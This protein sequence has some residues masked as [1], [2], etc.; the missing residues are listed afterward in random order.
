VRARSGQVVVLG[1]LMKEILNDVVKK[2][3]ILG[4]IPGINA[5]FRS[6][7][8]ISEKT[9][10]VILMRPVIVEDNSW[11][12]DINRSH[13]HIRELADEYRAR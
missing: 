9:E 5:L 4:D 8:K 10:L 12:D 13:T 2:Q 1:G 7:Q 11:Q 6:K 3:P